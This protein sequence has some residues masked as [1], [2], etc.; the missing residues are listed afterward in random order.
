MMNKFAYRGARDRSL[1]FALYAASQCLCASSL[2]LEAEIAAIREDLAVDKAWSLTAAAKEAL[3][4]GSMNSKPVEAR[5]MATY[6]QERGFK[7]AA[8]DQRSSAYRT[9][10]AAMTF[11]LS[12]SYG[13]NRI[14]A[15]GGPLGG[16]SEF[17]EMERRPLRVLV[18][19]ARA[20]SSLPALWWRETLLSCYNSGVIG[21]GIEIG[22][23]G[24][25]LQ[26]MK[27]RDNKITFEMHPSRYLGDTQDTGVKGSAY[28]INGGQALL[29]EH[30]QH[31]QLLLQ[32]DLFVLFKPGLGH[33][34]LREDWG[35]MIKLL[36]MSRKPVLCTAHSLKDLQRDKEFLE[37]KLSPIGKD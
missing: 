30:P 3:G 32:S 23:M 37:S 36:C 19:G 35:N 9:L 26:A 24:P 7:Q 4:A 5:D 11:P 31:M 28:H 14:F 27:A 2:S 16:M 25:G 22:L 12:L 17:I 13:V 21:G 6:M 8:E 18:V 29:H 15:K 10:S 20:E 34:A 33:A 1:P